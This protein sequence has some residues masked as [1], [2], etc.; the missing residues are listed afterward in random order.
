MFGVAYRYLI[1]F[2]A[3]G[4]FLHPLRAEETP[5]YSILST[6]I[7]KSCS[8]YFATEFASAYL[9]SGGAIYD[10]H[11]VASHELGWFFDFDDYGWIDGYLWGVSSLDNKQGDS[12][13]MFLNEL[14]MTACYGRTWQV[15]EEISFSS[16]LGPLWN[17]PIGYYDL[18]NDY[19]GPHFVFQL[20]NPIA[21]AYVSG[22]WRVSPDADE[23]CR[24]RFGLTRTF[25]LTTSLS[26]TPMIE[27]VWM[28][29]RYYFSRFGEYPENCDFDG[30]FSTVTS[31]ARL[32]WKVSENFN[33]YFRLS[34]F[35]VVNPQARA[36]LK[37]QSAYYAV[38]DWPVFRVGAEYIF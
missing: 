23:R 14:E 33:V 7:L 2:A 10:T 25:A 13:R 34:M 16:K 38:R 29:R 22:L 9:I 21:T 18:H 36:A 8:G 35:D 30:A 17:P 3:A 19:W 15:A 26:I 20:D 1:I 28:D 31:S 12:H 27:T 32:T 11:P 5:Q 6:N 24:I 4:F 37:Q